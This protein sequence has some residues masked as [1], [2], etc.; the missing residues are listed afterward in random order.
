M[1]VDGASRNNLGGASAEGLIGND[2][3]CRLDGFN[4]NLGKATNVATLLG[5]KITKS[6]GHKELVIETDLQFAISLIRVA[7]EDSQY[8]N[9]IAETKD[10]PKFDWKYRLEPVLLN[11]DR[12]ATWLNYWV[13]G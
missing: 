13:R 7:S 4:A 8:R 3:G 12:I 10:M 2:Q 1:N 9:L 5:L 6:S 11:S